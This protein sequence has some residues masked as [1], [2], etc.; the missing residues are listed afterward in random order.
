MRLIDM[1]PELQILIRH[2]C[3]LE[4]HRGTIEIWKLT[5]AGDS[6]GMCLI[7]HLCRA[8]REFFSAGVPKNP[9][10]SSIARSW[11]GAS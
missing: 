9:V 6:R 10:P 8:R 7:N 5:P 1:P 2:P 11:H 3:L 4:I